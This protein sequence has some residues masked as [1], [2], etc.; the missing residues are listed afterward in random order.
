MLQL[1]A[2]SSNLLNVCGNDYPICHFALS[3]WFHSHPQLLDRGKRIKMMWSQKYNCPSDNSRFTLAVCWMRWRKRHGI[4]TS[5]R[6]R[7]HQRLKNSNPVDSVFPKKCSVIR[8]M[9]PRNMNFDKEDG[10]LSD[11]Y[12]QR[13]LLPQEWNKSWRSNHWY[14][15]F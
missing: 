4:M 11:L 1:A 12:N 10:P 13:S 7:K 2:N 15:K 14:K 8:K 5:L 3:C 9:A 6:H